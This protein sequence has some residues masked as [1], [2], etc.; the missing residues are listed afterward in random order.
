[1]SDITAFVGTTGGAGTTRVT[2]EVA[3]TLARDGD[4]VAILDAAYATQGL[5]D[6]V[7]GRIDPDV[8]ALVT[9]EWP[10]D[11]GLVEL[12]V[13]TSGR[14][15]AAPAYA[16]FER[17]ARAKTPDAAR[18]FERLAE[19][20]ARE[21]D[22]VLVDTPPIAANQAVAAVTVADRVAL[23]TPGTTRGTD[24]LARMRDRL[25]DVGCE[26]DASVATRT[27]ETGVADVAVPESDTTDPGAVPVCDTADGALAAAVVEATETTLDRDLDVEFDDGLLGL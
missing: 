8:T 25:A 15:V 7:Q 13:E 6:H 19:T 20:A 18:R 16:P 9:E 11:D 21:Y 22:A 27:T 14:V 12:P 2:V 17:L 24:A 26:V 5:A 3:A 23:V 4:D 1:M 10:L